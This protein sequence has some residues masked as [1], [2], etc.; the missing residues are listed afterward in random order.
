MAVRVSGISD[1]RPTGI[2]LDGF[3]I[4]TSAFCLIHCLA[5]P[6]VFA[7]MPAA[8]AVLGTPE[9]FHLA[10]FVVAVP[11][12][13]IAMRSG[14]RHHGMLLPLILAALGLFLIGLGAV[15]G[16]RI[17]LETGVTVAGSLLLATGHL[18]NW[19]L[20]RLALAGPRRPPADDF[21]ATRA[22]S[23]SWIRRIAVRAASRSVQLI[24][25]RR[26]EHRRKQHL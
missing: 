16:F 11:A 7:L 12:S 18:R 5:L 1:H 9:W 19:R 4:G 2:W 23:P 22:S 17:L 21:G 15:G 20:Q 14:Y 10:A 6:L 26:V 13:A 25:E 3:A 24:G 8:V